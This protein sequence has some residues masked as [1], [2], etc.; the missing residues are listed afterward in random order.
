[1]VGLHLRR[2]EDGLFTLNVPEG[3]WL[4]EAYS[5]SRQMGLRLPKVLFLAQPPR[6]RV[7]PFLFQSIQFQQRSCNNCLFAS[8]L[9]GGRVACRLTRFRCL[10]AALP[11]LARGTL[12]PPLT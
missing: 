8:L 11:P 2:T 9:P 1:M 12:V 10:F 7:A 3:G 5:A 4:E 6:R